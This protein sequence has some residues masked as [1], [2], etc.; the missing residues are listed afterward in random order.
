MAVLEAM[1]SS[2]A[3]VSYTRKTDG[4][5]KLLAL[6]ADDTTLLNV[7]VMAKAEKTKKEKE[8][9]IAKAPAVE[10]AAPNPANPETDTAVASAATINKDKS[11]S[12][13]TVA[14]ETSLPASTVNSDTASTV[15]SSVQ[16]STDDA[17]AK[18]EK[19]TGKTEEKKEDSPSTAE[20]EPVFKRSVITRRSES[21]TSDGFG[22]VFLDNNDTFIDTIRLLIPNPKVTFGDVA[23]EKPADDK[24]F[25]EINNAA[26]DDSSATLKTEN[27][28]AAQSTS[29]SAVATESDLMKLRKSMAAKASEE[30][31][32]AEAEKQFKN[33]CF[34]TEQVKNLSTL[35]L[36]PKGKYTFFGAAYPHVSDQEQFAVLESELKADYFYMNR[37]KALIAK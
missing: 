2:N 14:A 33:K 21:S 29:C 10:A 32:I 27:A 23:A 24:K 31:M 9:V 16:N 26:S 15:A 6:A 19:V 4:F 5:T 17:A 35:I 12:D 20:A 11:S 34:T 7:P 22:L 36:T 1:A 30:N 37:F 13:N 18:A 8:E 28:A 3:G 25:L